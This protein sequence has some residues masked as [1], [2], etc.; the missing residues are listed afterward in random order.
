MAKYFPGEAITTLEHL[1]IDA[2]SGPRAALSQFITERAS[3]SEDYQAMSGMAIEDLEAS[4]FT[5]LLEDI[6]NE[7]L[8]DFAA[9]KFE[10]LYP[11]E[12]TA[13]E[14]DDDYGEIGP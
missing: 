9:G 8:Y 10:E 14:P 1:D 12:Y 7:S 2:D 13:W 6:E 4:H 11:D 5:K 3:G